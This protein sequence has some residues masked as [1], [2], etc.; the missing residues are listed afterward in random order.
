VARTSHES[1]A[2]PTTF[3][4][5]D[6]LDAIRLWSDV[7][8]Q[9]P[10]MLDWDPSRARRLGQAW[11][12]E[13][14]EEGS[15]PTASLVRKRFG[16][17]S[18]AVESAGVAPRRGPSR[19][20]ANLAGPDAILAALIEWTR[21]YGDV[22]AMADWD[23][24]R[25]RRLGQ[26]WRIARYRDGDWPSARSVAHHF[27]SFTNAVV[28]AGL[29]PRERGR[30]HEDRRSDQAA[31][32]LRITHALVE[33]R[34]PGV[35]DL[36]ACLRALA[37]ARRSEDPVST[38]GAL[39]DLAASALAWAQICGM[40]PRDRAFPAPPVGDGTSNPGCIPGPPLD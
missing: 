14:F 25:A 21:R 30:H 1:P 9:A 4:D 5:R 7:Y 26:L 37:A 38:H 2:R 19:L 40:D 11:R 31:N 16:Q 6:I 29:I 22:P 32:R 17:F 23:P 28:H 3:S 39:V 34:R 10:T 24:H 36:A 18:A 12:A 20:A 33:S 8:T 15:W 27:G 35:D 13:R